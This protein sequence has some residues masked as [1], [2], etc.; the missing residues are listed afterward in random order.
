[1]FRREVGVDGV[2]SG[3]VYAELVV[4]QR[5]EAALLARAAVDGG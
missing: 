5:I 3:L 2:V 1:M 4:V